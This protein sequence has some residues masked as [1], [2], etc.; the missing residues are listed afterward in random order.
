MGGSNHYNFKAF[1]IST[2]SKLGIKCRIKMIRYVGG[3]NGIIA[4]KQNGD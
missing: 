1:D 4:V 3:M 2:S